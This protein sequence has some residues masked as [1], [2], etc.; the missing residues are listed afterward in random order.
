MSIIYIR[1]LSGLPVLFN[2]DGVI[3]CDRSTS[4][5]FAT[6]ACAIKCLKLN[7]KYSPVRTYIIKCILFSEEFDKLYT[8]MK[9]NRNGIVYLFVKTCT[10]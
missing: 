5:L 2:K 1:F 10:S 3:S 7:G 8:I 4:S 9:Y 6:D